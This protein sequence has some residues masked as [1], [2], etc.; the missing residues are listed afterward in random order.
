MITTVTLNPALD[1]TLSVSQIKT[2]D[3]NRVHAV[4]K[5]PGGKGFN[6]SRIVKRLGYPTTA[7]GLLGGPDG[8]E[9]LDLLKREGIYVWHVPIVGVTR[10][11]V[12]VTDRN[13][14]QTKFNEK[15]PHIKHDEFKALSSLLGQVMDN[16]K[17]LV[18]SGSLPP[19]LP[20]GTYAPLIR[21]A[22][23]SN[24]K[25]KVVMDADGEA[26]HH[27]IKA[28]PF[29]IKPNVYELNRL[30]GTAFTEST[31][32]AS[33][34]LPLRRLI[35]RGPEAV[36]LS[37]GSRGILY[38]DAVQAYQAAAPKV[39]VRTTVG[40]GD[41]LLAGF[42]T[43]LAKGAPVS[44]CLQLGLA[45]AGATVQQRGTQLAALRDIKKLLP[46]IVV[47]KI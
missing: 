46:K 37:L 28:R 13:G 9:V 6:V 17:I 5:D 41:S 30:L 27:A 23:A 42:V 43:G 34:L 39:P 18:L 16:A 14:V 19:G 35:E 38:V 24:S 29:L 26:L 44:E 4:R 7:I 22:R 36:L 11:N 2:D 21:L 47:S 31:P 33:L 10:V 12:T 20:D 45:C 25:L 15:G 3:S 40:A 8:A 1:L 32:S